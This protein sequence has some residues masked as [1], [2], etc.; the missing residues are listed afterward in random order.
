MSTGNT[1]RFNTIDGI[2]ASVPMAQ[3]NYLRAE[4][5]IIVDMLKDDM[6]A[7]ESQSCAA[8]N[9]H[10][11]NSKAGGSA[12]YLDAAERFW[13]F[14]VQTYHGIANRRSADAVRPLRPAEP[15]VAPPPQSAPAPVPLPSAM[16]QQ[17]QQPFP[18]VSTPDPHGQTATGN[19]PPWYRPRHT[20]VAYVP[21]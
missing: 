16:P 18:A 20:A 3:G 15:P 7:E 8:W 19:P 1:L 12:C 2:I 9:Q 17:R 6:T 13:K 4:A 21:V 11:E 14:A 10:V 5:R